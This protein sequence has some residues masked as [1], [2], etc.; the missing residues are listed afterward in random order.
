VT[1][2]NELLGRADG[3]PGQWYLHTFAPEQPDLDW[4]NERV[5]E[6]FDA[7]V[8]FWFDRGVDGFRV[9][10][11][12]AMAKV[13]GLPDADYGGE[14]RFA[15]AEWVGNPHW[16]VDGVHDILRRFR[17]VAD[18]YDGDRVFVT[19]AVVNGPERLSRYVRPDEMHTAFNFEFLDCRWDAA[20]Y[21]A[22]GEDLVQGEA[23]SFEVE[24][25]VLTEDARW[26]WL[27]QRGQVTEF[28]A[29]G[30]PLCAAG[31][32]IEIDARKRA[33]VV[34]QEKESKLATALWG[35]RAAFWHWNVTSDVQAR[36]SMWFAMTG[37]QRE[38]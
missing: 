6:D 14:L 5:R 24:Y 27:L 22:R 31:I 23:P 7:I 32:C 9:D 28:D 20:E 21:R 12:P 11:V 10:A 3:R 17:A 37:Y 36:S 29:A 25:R 16:D 4:S 1:V 19:E 38:E 30:Q 2:T 13:E 35:A 34:L 15:S 33:E 18:S 8:R 26:V